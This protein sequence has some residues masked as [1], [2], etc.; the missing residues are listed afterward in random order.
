MRKKEIIEMIEVRWEKTKDEPLMY[1]SDDSMWGLVRTSL[2]D[3][4]LHLV[5]NGR[6]VKLVKRFE[7]YGCDPP[8][9]SVIGDI[10]KYS[11]SRS[12]SGWMESMI[13]TRKPGQEGP[14]GGRLIPMQTKGR[15]R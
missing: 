12:K 6:S 14:G 1:V 3:W 7:K 13:G 10:S 4:E 8:F 2:E 5:R 9:D 15:R 11:H